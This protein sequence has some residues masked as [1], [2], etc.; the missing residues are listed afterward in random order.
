MESNAASHLDIAE[1]H[2]RGLT[3][4]RSAK[5]KSLRRVC[6]LNSYGMA[7]AWRQF[8]DGSHPGQHLWG[9]LELVRMGYEIAMPDEPAQ[10]GPLFN[11]RRQDLKHI[12]F[13]KSWL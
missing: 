2:Y 13:A 6:Y 8:R 1:E 9:C 4:L 12:R 3:I 11:Y 10:S 7:T 5:V